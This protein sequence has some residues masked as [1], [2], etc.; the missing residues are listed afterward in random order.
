M[1]KQKSSVQDFSDTIKHDPK[2][3]IK[4]CL[5]EIKEYQKLI[6]ILEQEL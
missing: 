2:K 1:K 4:W 6:K 5:R 3:I